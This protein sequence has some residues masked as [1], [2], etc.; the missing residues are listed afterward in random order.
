MALPRLAQ[1]AFLVGVEQCAVQVEDRPPQGVVAVP[2]ALAVTGPAGRLAQAARAA[3][4]DMEESALPQRGVHVLPLGDAGVQALEQVPLE[5]LVAAL[6]HRARAVV[7]QPVLLSID[8]HQVLERAGEGGLVVR[9]PLGKVDHQVG[10]Q[11]GLRQQVLVMADVVMRGHD[12][13]VVVGHPVA[14]V[15]HLDGGV[16]RALVEGHRPIA[17]GVAAQHVLAHDPVA[18]VDDRPFAAEVDHVEIGPA[19]RRVEVADRG[20]PGQA[21]DLGEVAALERRVAQDD[22]APHDSVVIAQREERVVERGAQQR[23]VGEQHVGA[24]APAVKVLHEVGLEDDGLPRRDES[25]KRVP[26]GRAEALAVEA[27]AGQ[28][29]AKQAVDGVRRARQ[30]PLGGGEGVL[31]IRLGGREGCGRVGRRGGIAAEHHEAGV[32][33]GVTILQ[34]PATW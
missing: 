17:G 9:L 2:R 10:R 33:H 30:P 16:E 31:G 21:D 15:V 28:R 24:Q 14:R 3:A 7:G 19:G 20:D 12:L 22:P 4:R 23:P 25:P 32:D 29:L 11:D 18:R 13:G 1:H 6:G 5:V 27:E 26:P 8:A 34:E